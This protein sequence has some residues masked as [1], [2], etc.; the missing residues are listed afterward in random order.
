MNNLILGFLIS[1]V[2]FSILVP[3]YA[4][5]TSLKTDSSFYKGGSKIYFSGTILDTDASTVTV[6]I[7]DPNNQYTRIAASGFAN[8]THQFQIMVDTSAIDNQQK[9]SL[10]GIYNATAFVAQ[11][12]NGKTVSFAFSPDGSPLIASP[13]TS[14]VASARSSTEI[15]LSWSMGANNAG[16]LISGYRIERNDG[17]GFNLI[18]NTQTTYFSDLGLVP[19]KQYSYRVSAI[20]SAGT[21]SPSTIVNATT[22]S[23]PNVP[24]NPIPNNSNAPSLDELLQQRMK[25]AEKLQELLHGSHSSGSSQPPLGISHNIDLTEHVS[26]NDIS[27]TIPTKPILESNPTQIPNIDIKNILYLLISFAGVGIVVTVLY[28]RKKRK[29]QNDTINPEI[30]SDTSKEIEA[31]YPMLILKN[32]LAKGEI[33]MDEFKLLKNELSEP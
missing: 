23:P 13:P 10:K 15:D 1:L 12:E 19:N 8:S 20:N 2:A 33:T 4:E 5:V 22:L 3:A 32:R 26:L 31:D 24:I 27:N 6:L 17:S 25:D 21:S 14:L 18:Q 28:L 29:T 30:S 9:L 16:S 11:K 7:F